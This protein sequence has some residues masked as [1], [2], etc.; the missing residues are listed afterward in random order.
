M[1]KG[2]DM[3]NWLYRFIHSYMINVCLSLFGFYGSPKLDD[4]N[5]IE[6]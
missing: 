6:F 4:R 3:E 1:K 2:I 5:Y